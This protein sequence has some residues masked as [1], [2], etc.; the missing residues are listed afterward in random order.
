MVTDYK[1]YYKKQQEVYDKVDQ[2]ELIF[3][4]GDY[5]ATVSNTPIKDLVGLFGEATIN[6]NDDNKRHFWSNMRNFWIHNNLK[7]V[8]Q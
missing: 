5:N 1:N 6:V 8:I 3:I 2:T 7:N 4:C